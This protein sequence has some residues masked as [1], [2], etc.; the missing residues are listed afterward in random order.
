MGEL[1]ASGHLSVV[2]PPV[3]VPMWVTAWVRQRCLWSKR[4]G[5]WGGSQCIVGVSL[6]PPIVFTGFPRVNGSLELVLK[7]DNVTNDRIWLEIKWPTKTRGLFHF[8]HSAF[9]FYLPY[10]FPDNFQ[11]SWLILIKCGARLKGFKIHLKLNL[12]FRQP[13]WN[14]TVAS[15]SF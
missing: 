13:S 1:K 7:S 8:S 3:K 12:W 6:P 11:R 15:K 14:K 4:K 5:R 10:L 9:C 2:Y